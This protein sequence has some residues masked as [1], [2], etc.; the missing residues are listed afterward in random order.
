MY[1]LGRNP[2]IEHTTTLKDMKR[3]LKLTCE[4]HIARSYGTFVVVNDD[5]VCYDVR[6][7]IKLEKK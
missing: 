1:R 6:V 4:A 3:A 7:E 2:N 5:G